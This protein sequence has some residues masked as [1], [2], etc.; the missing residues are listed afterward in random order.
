MGAGLRRGRPPSREATP[1]PSPRAGEA[2]RPSTPRA[3]PLRA[4]PARRV[5]REHRVGPPAQWSASS[6]DS[7]RAFRRAVE[8]RVTAEAGGRARAGGATCLR[9][10]V[11]AGPDFGE[12]AFPVRPVEINR[13]SGTELAGKLCE[14]EKSNGLPCVVSL[15]DN[16][17][18]KVPLGTPALRKC[19]ALLLRARHCF[20]SCS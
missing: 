17:Q 8:P 16:H 18:A 5:T 14:V 10:Q 1:L 20:E 13:A 12:L 9:H 3:G 7:G 19:M 6:R 4:R 2:P 11:W 15:E